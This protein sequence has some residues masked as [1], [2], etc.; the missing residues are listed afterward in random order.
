MWYQ[1]DNTENLRKPFWE[2]LVGS[3]LANFGPDLPSKIDYWTLAPE[4]Q[5]AIEQDAKKLITG[6]LKS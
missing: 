3:N 2:N 5:F 1:L 6:T 4:L